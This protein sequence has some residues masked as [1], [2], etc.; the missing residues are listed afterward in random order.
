MK[1]L[2]P[3]AAMLCTVFFTITAVVFTA[4][5][6]ANASNEEVRVLKFWMIGLGALG[7]AGIVAGI[8]LVRT[9][10]YAMAAG[11]AFLPTVLIFMVF[12]V[13]VMRR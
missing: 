2:L 4:S 3:I 7:L 5:M 1:V 12:L 9:G 10:R 11:V 8:M 13:A 6:G